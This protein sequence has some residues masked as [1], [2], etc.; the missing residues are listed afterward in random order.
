VS[1]QIDLSGQV[2]LVTGASRGLGRVIACRLAG[3]GASV[4]IA[5]RSAAGL[6][7]TRRLITE[8]GGH[9]LALVLDVTD[10]AAVSAAVERVHSDMGPIDVLIN[11]AGVS[12]P[13]VPTWEVDP[14]EWWRTV[15]I[16]LRGYF[17]LHR[18]VLPGMLQRHSGRIVDLTSRAGVHRW[19]WKTAYSVSKGAVVKLVENLAAELRR[20]PIA[21]FAFHPGIVDAGL[22]TTLY[23]EEVEPGSVT[24]RVRSWFESRIAAGELVPPE[25]VAGFVLAL[26]SGRYDRLSGCYLTVDDDLDAL[27]L[28]ID[29]I[30]RDQLLRLRVR[31]LE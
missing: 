10:G 18:A 22:T 7:E 28:R 19:P 24:E 11:N 26:V 1:P 31:S 4:A 5:A 23:D 13:T 12:G 14:D 15:E 29:E 20:E 21:I 2:A 3:S 8:S 17:L 30:E 27:M 16:N 6:D 25:R 9:A